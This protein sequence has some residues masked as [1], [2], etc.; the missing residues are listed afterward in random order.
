MKCFVFEFICL[1]WKVPVS[2]VSAVR[3]FFRLTKNEKPFTIFPRES[4]IKAMKTAVVGGGASGM[5]FAIECARRGGEVTLYER[6][7]RVG[8]KLCATGGGRCNLLNAELSFSVYNDAR[9]AEK[10]FTLVP[11]SRIESFLKSTGLFLTEPDER[12][13]I[14]PVTETASTVVDCLRFALLR[15]GVKS[16][17]AAVERIEKTR[18]KFTV[19]CSDGDGGEF[20]KVV[21]ACGSGSQTENPRLDRFVDGKYLTRTEPSL[22]PLKVDN[23][24]KGIG[25]VRVK[26]R[27]ALLSGSRRLGVQE[28]EIQFRDFGL[29][30]IMMFDLSALIARERV[31]GISEKYDLK[32]DFLPFLDFCRLNEELEYR[33]SCGAGRD[34]V[35]RGLLQ[36]KLA[37]QIARRARCFTAAELARSAKK[38]IFSNAVT[39]SYEMSQV[40]C[41]GVDVNCLDEGLALPDGTVVVGEAL[42]MDGLCGGYNLAFAF[43]SALAAADRI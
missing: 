29:S 36:G 7:G 21:L 23:P 43:A 31:A 41:G 6:H 27:G 34:G 18:G 19:V 11:K 28:G 35:F 20:D 10:I 25:G 9:F 15:E 24:L 39:M 16:R 8:K 5:V 17:F 1:P 3:G 37:D 4:I 38:H 13:R 22:T 33:L 14:Y 32:V 40:T 26:A 30:G 42:N 12:G 2:P